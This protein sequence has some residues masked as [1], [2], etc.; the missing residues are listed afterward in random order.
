MFIV[1]KTRSWLLYLRYRRR[2]Y[3]Y[4]DEMC[5]HNLSRMQ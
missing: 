2:Y 1:T 5:L 4:K 3:Y